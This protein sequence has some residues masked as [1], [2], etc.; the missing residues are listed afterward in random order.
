MLFRSGRTGQA[1][2]AFAVEAGAQVTLHDTAEAA[3]LEAASIALRGSGV[4]LAFGPDAPLAPL[5]DAAHLVVHS[6]SVTLGFPSVKSQVATPLRAFAARALPLDG[7]PDARGAVLISEPEWTLRLLGDRT[8]VG[9]TGT[10]G[11]TTTA[12]LIAAI[13][14][15]DPSRP[16]E[17]IGRAHV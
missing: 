12:A 10:K 13:L 17:Q 1:T 16:V 14:S 3:T 2:A 8:V 7:P 4:T 15:E 6:P 5:L 9:I 11:K